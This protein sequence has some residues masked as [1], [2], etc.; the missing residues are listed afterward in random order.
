M[1]AREHAAPISALWRT[2]QLPQ[3]SQD[4]P[5]SSHKKHLATSNFDSEPKHN[6]LRAAILVPMSVACISHYPCICT[7]SLTSCVAHLQFKCFVV[8]SF[9][10]SAF[11]T[12]ACH[13][14]AYIYIY[15][16]NHRSHTV[17]RA[18]VTK[19]GVAFAIKAELAFRIG[20]FGSRAFHIPQC[21]LHHIG[22]TECKQSAQ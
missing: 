6:N 21:G 10:F 20:N 22:C 18:P 11:F 13:V 15:I 5:R 8:L 17:R 3:L 2:S 7:C 1:C 4:C 14:H 9:C 19:F 16:Y 12:S